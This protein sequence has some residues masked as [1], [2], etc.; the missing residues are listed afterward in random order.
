VTD[1]GQDV[2]EDA[3]PDRRADGFGCTH[4][5]AAAVLHELGAHL[6]I[7]TGPTG[8]AEDQHHGGDA[9]TEHRRKGKDQQDAGDG[10]EDVVQPLEKVADLAAEESGK[11]AK[12]G[13]D[14]GCHQRCH[15][16]DEDRNLRSLDRLGQHVPAQSVGA[17]R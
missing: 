15:H 3:A 9:A 1:I 8:E 2:A 4:V 16:A 10:L 7:Q 13:A 11:C 12:Q 5:L 6:P 17:H 14:A